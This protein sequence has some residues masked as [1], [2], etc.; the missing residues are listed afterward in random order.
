MMGKSIFFKIFVI[1]AAVITLFIGIMMFAQS[2]FFE[3]YYIYVKTQN[4]KSS[5]SSL[6]GAYSNSGGILDQGLLGLTEEFTQKNDSMTLYIKAE[7]QNQDDQIKFSTASISGSYY[8][9]LA[10]RNFVTEQIQY[11]R[12]LYN[13]NRVSMNS[14]ETRMYSSKDNYGNTYMVSVSAILSGGAEKGLLYT[15][16]S[17]QPAGEASEIMSSYYIIFFAVAIVIALFLSF[18]YSRQISKPLIHLNR[19][20]SRIAELDF[21][22]DCNIRSK[23]ELGNLSRTINKLAGNMK[24]YIGRLSES[25]KRLQEEL[26]KEKELDIMRNEFVA[27]ASHELKTPITVMQGYLQGLQDKIE[28]GDSVD[29]YLKILNDETQRMNTLVSDMLNLS[30]LESGKSKLN[31]EPLSIYRIFEYVIRKLSPAIEEKKI[32]VRFEEQDDGFL[33]L[34]DS[35][36][37]EQVVTNLLDNAVK[38]TSFGGTVKISI[39]GLED[40]SLIEIENTGSKI[41]EGDKEKIWEKFYRIEKS[42]NKFSGGSGLGLSIVRDILK[43]HGSIYGVENTSSGVKFFFTLK[44]YEEPAAEQY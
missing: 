1:T 4:L 5:I 29:E 42:R 43:L 7:N 21:T 40:K 33:S 44:K 10:D 14:G 20:A 35:F 18:M 22:M 26:V 23:D 25:N 11:G 34:G 30:Q 36:R 24:S 12:E 31:M 19:V 15:F 13:Q 2:A 6:A 3:K 17:L 8:N 27:G 41:P 32:E 39:T 38:Y 9:M 16:T 37:V 28:I